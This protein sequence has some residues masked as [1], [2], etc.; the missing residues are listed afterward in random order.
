MLFSD[1]LSE[2]EMREAKGSNRQALLDL[3]LDDFANAFPG[4]TF[5]L[6]LEYPIINAQALALGDKRVVKIYGGLALHPR[7]G[8]E[9]LTFITLHEAGHHLARGCRSGRD[10]SLACE[11]A[12]DCWA[13]TVGAR[14]LL[15]ESGRRLQVRAAL[16]ELDQVMSP[17]QASKRRY[18]ARNRYTKRISTS[19]CWAREWSL[20]S[21]AV[22]QR[23]QPPMIEG[24]CITY[25]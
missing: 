4:L 24:F 21:R 22:F 18:T 10:P 20:R 13:V 2:R 3:L 11:C 14:K 25:I 23:A 16:E 9:A 19:G 5:E 7:L 17:R 15:Q 8:A 12:S 6:G 1:R